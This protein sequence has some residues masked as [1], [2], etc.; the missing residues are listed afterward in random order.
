MKLA[1]LDPVLYRIV[2]ETTYRKVDDVAG[3]QGLSFLCPSCFQDNGG[4]VGT[5]SVLA[6]FAGRG[7]PADTTPG[8]G[9]WAVSGTSLA[10]ITLAPSIQTRCWHGF[11][12]NG[13]VS[14]C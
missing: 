9:R 2:D 13:E 1:D 4:P 6:W 5:H 10:D 7:V 3:A 11:V 8:P 12:T 14:T